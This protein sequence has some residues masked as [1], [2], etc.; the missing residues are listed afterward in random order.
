MII[1]SNGLLILSPLLAGP[2]GPIF[3]RSQL[4][5]EKVIEDRY[6]LSLAG[7]N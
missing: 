5:K 2:Q 4:I 3:D 6:G 7:I 1:R